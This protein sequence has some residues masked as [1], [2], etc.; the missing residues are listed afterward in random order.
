LLAT[1]YGLLVGS[2]TEKIGGEWH[3]RLAMLPL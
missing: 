3:A 2:D 1:S